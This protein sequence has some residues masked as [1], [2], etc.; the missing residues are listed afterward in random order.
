MEPADAQ[1]DF[2]PEIA[3][4]HRPEDGLPS[5]A[6]QSG[7]ELAHF[8]E[9]S[10]DLLCVAGLDGYLKRVNPAWTIVL[11]WSLEELTKRPF[12]EFV[13]PD[14]RAA[15][16]AEMDRLGA[17]TPATLFENRYLHRNGSYKWLQWNARPA[18]GGGLIFASA[19][20][21][22]R[23]KSLE[24][25]ILR[26]ADREKEHL[27]R[28]L[29]DGVCQSL[30]GIA[31]LS[32]TLARNLAANVEADASAA[33][34]EIARLLNDVIDQAR[35]LAHG[36]G[37][38]GLV[39]A[40]LDRALETLAV[41]VERMFDITCTVDFDGACVQFPYEVKLH[42]L[43]IA[44]EAV[45]NAVTHG[46]ADRIAIS[47]RCPDGSCVLSVRDN[48][49]GISDKAGN[50]V[51]VGLHNMAARAR[52]LGGSL[53]ISRRARQGTNVTCTFPEPQ[54]PH[55]G[56]CTKAIVIVEDHP[57][58]R[59]GL[60]ALIDSVP[61]LA[62]AAEA[63]TC[64]VALDAIR[65]L[66]PDLVI[67][68][69]A[70]GEDDGLD[71]V[72]AIKAQHPGIPSLVLSMFDEAVYAERSLRAGARGYVNKRQLDDTLLLAIQRVLEG[73]T[74]MSEGLQ[75]RLANAYLVG[76]SPETSPRLSVLSD[77]E[78]QVYRLI[79][80]GLPTRDIAE[81]L[82]LSIKTIESH[83]EHIKRKLAFK[84]SAE[85]THDATCWVEGT[86]RIY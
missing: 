38:A 37:P 4:D 51:G 19:R 61:D 66:Q 36:L 23:Q 65:R 52:L 33:A 82:H 22:T 74:Y 86:S 64:H 57:I 21:I 53:E 7:H 54:A 47:F 79:G 59:R 27:G 6:D 76:G 85:L 55:P 11:G 35:D 60:V 13:H 25:E 56:S 43:R 42:L 69:L 14:D 62:I 45:S 80:Q 8:F 20:E 81:H 29:H 32:S 70:L 83:R 40:D 72:R 41:N 15:T 46:E 10:L 9:Q 18:P 39:E 75:R 49:V 24:R 1:R 48:G 34:A 30:A 71:L 63:A 3:V 12:L 84:S 78:L 5:R 17:G 50:S 77:R 44:Q 31:A 68:D 58:A 2:A 73:E 16:T 67:V 28:E 26:I